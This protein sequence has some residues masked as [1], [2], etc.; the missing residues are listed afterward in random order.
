MSTDYS[1][2]FYDYF[3]ESDGDEEGSI[4][5]EIDCSRSSDIDINDSLSDH[6]FI[7][8]LSDTGSEEEQHTCSSLDTMDSQLGLHILMGVVTLPNIEM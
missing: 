3:K 4:E 6:S 8:S 1:R 5:N 7:H 2:D